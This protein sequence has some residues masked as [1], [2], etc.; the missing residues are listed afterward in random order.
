MIMGVAIKH[1]GGFALKLVQ[2]FYSLRFL[3]V[4]IHLGV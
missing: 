4:K 1:F 2:F 3:I